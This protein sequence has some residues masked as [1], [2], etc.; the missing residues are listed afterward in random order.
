MVSPLD[1]LAPIALLAG[2]AALV[3]TAYV[4]LRG[5]PELGVISE[6]ASDPSDRPRG[7]GQ[8]DVGEPG[9]WRLVEDSPPQRREQEPDG[10]KLKERSA[11]QDE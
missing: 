10:E 4:V 5:R 6:R 1:A 3:C 7:E 9:G 2:L 11:G 8:G